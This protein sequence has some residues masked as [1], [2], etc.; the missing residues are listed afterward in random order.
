MPPI[1]KLRLS[2]LLLFLQIFLYLYVVPRG[3]GAAKQEDPG[4][5]YSLQRFCRLSYPPDDRSTAGRA[6]FLELAANCGV[7]PERPPPP[8]PPP[9]IPDDPPEPEPDPEPDRVPGL[10]V[11]Q[12][13][14]Q[15]KTKETNQP[16]KDES[17][18]SNLI[19]QIIM[20]LLFLSVSFALADCFQE[21]ARKRAN[22][23]SP[24]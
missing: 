14:P 19:Y 16:D 10:D 8:P 23:V 17:R 15:V 21:R 20:V 11:Q 13:P 24:H 1:S 5:G 12:A 18:S 4:G 22:P 9:D 6:F 7:R 3:N 2:I